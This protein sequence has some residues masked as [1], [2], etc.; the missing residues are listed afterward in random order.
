MKRKRNEEPYPLKMVNRFTKQDPEIWN[1]IGSLQE[2][3]REKNGGRESTLDLAEIG[4]AYMK[5]KSR[6]KIPGIP[7]TKAAAF[8]LEIASLFR[9]RKDKI[10]LDYD[11]NMA[12]ELYKQAND[13]NVP[14]KVLRSLPYDCFYMTL[15]GIETLPSFGIGRAAINGVFVTLEKSER[16]EKDRPPLHPEAVRFC[17]VG[18]NGPDEGDSFA[19]N[20][21]L[22]INENTIEDNLPEEIVS[23]SRNQRTNSM[24]LSS[25]Y[26]KTISLVIYTCARNR[27]IFRKPGTEKRTKRTGEIKDKYYEMQEYDVGTKIASALRL[28]LDDGDMPLL[29]DGMVDDGYGKS[30]VREN[31]REDVEHQ[32]EAEEGKEKI[33]QKKAAH[34]RRGHWHHYWKGPR[35]EPEKRVPILHW[36]PPTAIGIPSVPAQGTTVRPVA[37]K[38]KIKQR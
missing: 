33:R 32:V 35:S 16:M 14:S 31:D 5:Y 28:D 23:G 24:E 13:L 36:L 18:N 3:V 29:K 4:K 9:W 27:D 26:R 22:D 15:P 37:P 10:L 21:L 30:L 7:E 8:G 12:Q 17:L 11:P 6:K 34:I 19:I 25:F 2:K 1:V 20:F 38:K